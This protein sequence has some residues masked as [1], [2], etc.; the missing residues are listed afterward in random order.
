MPRE[1]LVPAREGETKTTSDGSL[2]PWSLDKKLEAVNLYLKVGNMTEVE[3]Q[4]GIPYKTLISWK[5]TRWYD[6]YV[7]SIK[8]ERDIQLSR[9]VED[10][11]DAAMEQ[12]SDRLKK[13]DTQ[14]NPQTG[15]M[16]RVPVKAQVINAISANLAKQRLEL[17]NQPT[18]HQMHD[19]DATNA[20]L[21]ELASAFAS[22]V[23][24]KQQPAIDV[25]EADYEEV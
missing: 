24:R 4:T 22:F 20:K 16:V 19:K 5:K 18:E 13:G 10:M 14:Y 2:T 12:M 7:R 25:D 8:G 21:Q 11:L 3:R 9:K 17:A 1:E 15:E 6:E 23:K